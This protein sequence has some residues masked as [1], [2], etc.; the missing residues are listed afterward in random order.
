MR[1]TRST[2]VGIAKGMG[3]PGC[4]VAGTNKQGAGHEHASD[5]FFQRVKATCKQTRLE[6]WLLKCPKP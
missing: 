5:T 3:G 1:A 6:L 4:A 2:N